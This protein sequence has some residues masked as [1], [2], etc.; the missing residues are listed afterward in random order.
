MILFATYGTPFGH[1]FTLR[2]LLEMPRGEILARPEHSGCE[3]CYVEVARWNGTAGRW[4]RFAFEKLFGSEIHPDWSA[5][6]TA[7]HLAAIINRRHGNAHA[8]LIHTLPNF[9]PP[10][11]PETQPG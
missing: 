4:E 2:D 1:G 10:H 3:G 6:R 9:T 7:G 11:E 5:E 8:S